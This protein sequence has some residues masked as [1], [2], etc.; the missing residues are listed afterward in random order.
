[1]TFDPYATLD[2]LGSWLVTYLLHSSLLLGAAWLLQARL[3]RAGESLWRTA[4]LAGVLTATL[5]VGL[6]LNPLTGTLHFVSVERIEAAPTARIRP[7]ALDSV[8]RT[9]TTFAARPPS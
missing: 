7:S 3:P 2:N 6:G 8:A 9:P 5:Q 4:L 1:M